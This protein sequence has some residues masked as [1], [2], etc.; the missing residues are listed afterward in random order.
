MSIEEI[1]DLPKLPLP[2]IHCGVYFLFRDGEVVY[3][4]Q[5]INIASRVYSHIKEGKKDFDCYSFFECS[6][7]DLD[8]LEAALICKFDPEYNATIPPGQGFMSL[9]QW[10]QYRQLAGHH[11]KRFIDKTGCIPKKKWY[12][13]EEIDALYIAMEVHF[14]K[15]WH[16]N[17]RKTDMKLSEFQ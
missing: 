6:C 16:S 12:S 7:K 5:S 15:R 14:G 17:P 3:V 10:T 2:P 9:H 8:R 11:V 13:S 1:Q 4:G